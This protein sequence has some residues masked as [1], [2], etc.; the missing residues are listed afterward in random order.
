MPKELRL[1]T[2]RPPTKPGELLARLFLPETGMTKTAFADHIGIGR[3][4]LSEIINGHRRVTVDTA[5]R[6]SKALGNSVQ[7]WLNAQAAVDLYEGRIAANMA[8]IEKI[9]PI[10]V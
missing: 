3:D 4:R 5:M 9:Q 6:L 8:E 7:F 1:P 10:F 2:N